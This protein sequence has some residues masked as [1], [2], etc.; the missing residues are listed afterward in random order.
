MSAIAA[1]LARA[2]AAAAPRIAL[3]RRVRPVDRS[4]AAGAVIDSDVDGWTFWIGDDGIDHLSRPD[5]L[6]SETP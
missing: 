5:Y 1:L 3:T 4:C 2:K 6:E